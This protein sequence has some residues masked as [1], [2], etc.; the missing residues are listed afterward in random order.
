MNPTVSTDR[1]KFITT[2]EAARLLSI[3]HRTLEKWR[4]EQ[5]GPA[6]LKLGRVVRYDREAILALAP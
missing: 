4:L 2:K 6:F 3:S 5:K 1:S